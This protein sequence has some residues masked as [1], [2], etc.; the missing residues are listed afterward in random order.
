MVVL[1]LLFLLFLSEE[2]EEQRDGHRH[3]PR[4]FSELSCNTFKQ[5]WL[6]SITDSSAQLLITLHTLY[7]NTTSGST[8]LFVGNKSRQ[9]AAERDDFTCAEVWKIHFTETSTLYLKLYVLQWDYSVSFLKLNW[10][11][12]QRD[13]TSIIFKPRCS[14]R[15]LLNEKQEHVCWS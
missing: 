9:T 13:Y 12:L 6:F 10:Y 3:L 7:S 8:A 4:K 2:V 11:V 1:L 5:L 15:R 14:T